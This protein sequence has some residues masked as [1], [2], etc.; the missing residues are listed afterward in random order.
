[1]KTTALFDLI[2]VK[3]A[4]AQGDSEILTRFWTA[5]ESWAAAG[6]RRSVRLPGTQHSEEPR[7]LVVT[8]SDSALL[9]T[10][11]ELHLADFFT[12][13]KEMKARLEREAGPVYC[14]VN[15][16][17]EIP[18]PQHRVL[19]GPLLYE[20]GQPAFLNIAGS[21]AAWANLYLADGKLKAKKEWHGRF[22]TY[23]IGSR[24]LPPGV[25]T[26]EKTTFKAIDGSEVDLFAID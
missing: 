12:L 26:H 23:T 24:S 18:H 22:S 7:P 6:E 5:A 10:Y 25:V 19:G 8:Y 14:I 4:I 9:T 15:Q 20:P 11:R 3:K 21:G 17:E 2:G 16:D 1:M 13:V